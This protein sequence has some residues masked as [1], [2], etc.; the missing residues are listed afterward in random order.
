MEFFL[1]LKTFIETYSYVAFI[2]V[3]FY[4]VMFIFVM[5]TL[6]NVWGLRE[7]ATQKDA[8]I[9]F[10]GLIRGTLGLCLVLPR[11]LHYCE[12]TVL[13]LSFVLQILEENK[14]DLI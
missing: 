7:Q 2:T 14:F 5:I 11:G 1:L 10:C 6:T 4:L 12:C 8:K 9:M 13:M 3:L